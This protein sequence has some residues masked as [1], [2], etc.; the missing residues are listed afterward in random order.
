MK[1][2]A[3]RWIYYLCLSPLQGFEPALFCQFL[4]KACKSWPKKLVHKIYVVSACSKPDVKQAVSSPQVVAGT[5]RLQAAAHGDQED[6]GQ[7]AATGSGVRFMK[8]ISFL[9]SL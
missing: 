7:V 8:L 3:L 5:R 1:V 2:G 6:H 9:F 4:K